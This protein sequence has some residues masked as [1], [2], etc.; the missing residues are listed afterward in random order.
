MAQVIGP[1]PSNREVQMKLLTPT[2]PI[3]GNCSHLGNESAGKKSI[4][5]VSASIA[6]MFCARMKVSTEEIPLWSR[7]HL[8]KDTGRK[9]SKEHEPCNPAP[10][11]T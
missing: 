8:G 3:P 5:S 4:S 1:L 7:R 6:S 2:W 10:D 9:K 11:C